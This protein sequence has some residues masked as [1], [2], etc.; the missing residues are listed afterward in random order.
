MSEASL[1]GLAYPRL[2][3]S[4]LLPPEDPSHPEPRRTL[5][6]WVVDVLAV[7]ISA[8]FGVLAYSG[9]ISSAVHHVPDWQQVAD[10]VG[11]IASVVAIWWR[12]RHPVG[13]AL[14][15][16]LVSA[17]AGGAAAA[18]AV[19][20]FT[21]TVHRRSSV[22]VAFGALNI[23]VSAVFMVYRPQKEDWWVT[24]LISLIAVVV[25]VAWGMFVRARRQLIWTLRARAE[26]AETEQRILAEQA[27][28]AERTRIAREMHDV[29]AHRISLIALHA[30]GL[31]VRPD[32]PPEQVQETAELL[33]STAH[34]A[35][36]E[37][38]GVIGVLRDGDPDDAPAQP[39][40]TLQ[41]IPRLVDET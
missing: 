34:R 27:R 21:V 37:L 22:A 14:L 28:R 20:L 38:R 24:M 29:L 5:R 23:A 4:S 18:S 2:V 31:Q 6:D 30:G 33:R 26:R 32:L 12:R 11:S 36:E 9:S 16:A 3:P 41:D 35:L 39:Q 7:L 8:A 15:T 19:G 40:P 17:F 1:A 13:V 25:V 10:W